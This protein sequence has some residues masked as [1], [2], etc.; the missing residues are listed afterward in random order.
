[1]STGRPAALDG[2]LLARKGDAAP[3]ISNN[4]PLLEELGEPRSQQSV[5]TYGTGKQSGT[6]DGS[7]SGP[8]GRGLAWMAQHP[9]FGVLAFALGIAILFGVTVLAL[10]SGSDEGSAP[11]M[12]SPVAATAEPEKIEIPTDGKSMTQPADRKMEAVMKEPDPTPASPELP[13]VT[14]PPLPPAAA[15]APPKEPAAPKAAAVKPVAKPPVTKA[16]PPSRAGRYLL[17]LSAVPTAKSARSELTR[18]SKRLKG[19]LGN[20]KIIVVKAVP[21]GKPP[22]YRL[23]ASSYETRSSARNACKRIR[24]RKMACIVVRR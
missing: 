19:I 10:T 6:G 23:R 14:A 3:A 24:Q 9:I 21:P 18:L 16:P 5:G 13:K 2:S 7:P 8:L 22:I 11:I 4:S 20:R 12:P 1:M 15:I 17:Q